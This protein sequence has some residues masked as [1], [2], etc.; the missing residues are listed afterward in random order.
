M[1]WSSRMGCRMGWTS[2][3]GRWM[4]GLSSR[5]GVSSVGLGVACGC[6][7]RVRSGNSVWFMLAMERLG[8]GGRLLST[9]RLRLRALLILVTIA[10]VSEW[11][12][13]AKPA[14]PGGRS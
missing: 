5:L 3:L 7:H 2:R 9:L 12:L 10:T 4:G 14:V 6:R 13:L 1:G 11:S 8:V